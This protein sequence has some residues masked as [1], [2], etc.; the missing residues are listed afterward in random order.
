VPS[1]FFGST[2]LAGVFAAVFLAAMFSSYR[3]GVVAGV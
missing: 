3:W 2:F 1:V